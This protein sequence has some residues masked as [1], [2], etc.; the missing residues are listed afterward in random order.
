MSSYTHPRLALSFGNTLDV[1]M[2][3]CRV[4]SDGR[5][6]LGSRVRQLQRLGL[7]RLAPPEGRPSYGL[8]EIV[9]LATAMRLMAAFM[10]PTLAARYVLERWDV[11]SECVLAGAKGDIPTSY[12][13]R[14]PIRPVTLLV[15]EGS[16]LADLGRKGK[17]DDRYVGPL[18]NV[19]ATDPGSL[20]AALATTDGAAAILDSRTY[21]P[22]VLNRFRDR[23]AATETELAYELDRLRF[24]LPQRADFAH[25]Q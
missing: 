9:E 1:L 10:M 13:E 4:D 5:E 17:H 24:A 7:P 16:A 2:A 19:T 3:A 21:M 25:D 14:R 15:I 18:G 6:T 8:L 11:L 23:A 20:E 22:A 12:L